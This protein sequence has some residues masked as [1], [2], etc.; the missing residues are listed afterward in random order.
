M[1]LYKRL[2]G[3]WEGQCLRTVA[4]MAMRSVFLLFLTL[5]FVQTANGADCTKYTPGTAAD[6]TSAPTACASV[7]TNAPFNDSD[8][9]NL[10][11]RLNLY[12]AQLANGC[13]VQKGGQYAPSGSNIIELVGR[14]LQF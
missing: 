11:A 10:L 7:A 1:C 6:L 9:Q 12:R 13:A 3:F 4:I 8:R 14:K 2:N 5:M